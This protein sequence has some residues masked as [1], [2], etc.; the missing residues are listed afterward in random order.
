MALV[1]N[2]QKDQEDQVIKI[3]AAS[4]LCV[5]WVQKRFLLTRNDFKFLTHVDSKTSKFQIDS[6]R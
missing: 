3:F 4:L 5:C 2:L 6:S 1:R